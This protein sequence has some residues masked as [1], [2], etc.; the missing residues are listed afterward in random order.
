MTVQ[1][2][3][4]FPV[5]TGCALC[6]R[7]DPAVLFVE[8]T[9]ERG[10]DPQAEA[11][12]LERAG[13]SFALAAVPV[14]DWNR[15]LSPW[16]APPVF[17]KIP[18]AGGAQETLDRLLAD[19]LP[20]LTSRFPGAPVVLGGYSLAGLFALWAATRTPAFAAVNAASPSVWYPDFLPYVQAHPLR[21]GAVCLSL[22]DREER[23]KNPVMA[24]VGDCIRALH[25]LQSER[26]PCTL[27]W[28]PGNHFQDAPGRTAR[29]YLR[30]A[31]ALGLLP[32]PS[33][34]QKN[35]R[36]EPSL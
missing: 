1:K 23:A 22:G 31:A 24:R 12:V 17:G 27:D 11:A 8:L 28:N 6:S 10:G 33:A 30:C 26:T 9:E 7:G 13:L 2:E 36:Q 18:F 20:A 4:P 29:G 3:Q 19:V 21:T 32:G 16:P 5:G 35:Q 25:A 15:D 34:D 14:A